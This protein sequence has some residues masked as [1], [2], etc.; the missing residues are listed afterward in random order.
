[1]PIYIT[2]MLYYITC[3]LHN[4][5]VTHDVLPVRHALYGHH[6]YCAIIE[7]ISHHTHTRT[8]T[9]AHTVGASVRYADDAHAARDYYRI[10]I[11]TYWYALTRSHAHTHTHTHAHTHTHTHT[12]RYVYARCMYHHLSNTSI[13]H[14]LY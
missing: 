14:R 10:C 11:S 7:C 3:L 13:H 9:L 4:C 5:Y 8:H 6:V 12:H 1:M 2:I